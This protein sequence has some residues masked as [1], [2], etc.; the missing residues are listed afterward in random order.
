MTAAPLPWRLERVAAPNPFVVAGLS[1]VAVGIAF[2]IA[3]IFLMLTGHPPGRAFGDIYSGAFSG[4]YNFSETLLEATP[5]IFIGLGVG[6]AYRMSLWNIG[7]EGQFYMGAFVT[8]GIGLHLAWHNWTI[9]PA[10]MVGSIVAGA[11]WA[12]V[13][14]LLRAYL[15]V[16]EIITSLLLNY[17]G[18][19]WVDYFVF[20]PWRDPAELS[21]P[22]TPALPNNAQLPTLFGTRLNLAFGLALVAAVL[23][24]A[25]LRYTTWGY[26]LRIIGSNPRVA[27][28]AGISLRRNIVLVMAVSGAL[29]GLAG[30]AVMAGVSYQLQDGISP[31]YGYMAIIVA[32]LA[33][34]NPF[35]VILVAILFGG[36][37]NGGQNLQMDGIP[38]SIVNMIQASLLFS[39]LAVQVLTNYR[40]R[41]RHEVPKTVQEGAEPAVARAVHER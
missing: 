3:S 21:F 40:V 28:Y 41:R 10:M 4:S 22:I 2:L 12:A 11:C 34:G 16:S 20:G 31:G 29:A 15:G 27:M 24:W 8:T 18:V 39:I 36:L 5:L 9:V 32:V 6:L 19:L 33:R 7:G 14:G 26:E 17:V 30:F 38:Q 1:I 37:Q 35:G 23:I 25:V 13:P